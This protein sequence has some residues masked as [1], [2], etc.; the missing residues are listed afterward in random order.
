MVLIRF[1]QGK[2]IIIM[3]SF[4]YL[5]EYSRYFTASQNDANTSWGRVLIYDYHTSIRENY[6][7]GFGAS[8]RC[9]RQYKQNY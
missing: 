9:I 8:V 6:N 5:H 3:G 4:N 1:L 2:E 7:K